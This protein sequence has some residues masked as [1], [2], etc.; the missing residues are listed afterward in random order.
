MVNEVK[1]KEVI[2][3]SEG[4]T[5]FGAG[6]EGRVGSY[7]YPTGKFGKW[8][9]K[10][11]ATKAHPHISQ[12]TSP[13][14]TVLAPLAGDAAVT[15]VTIRPTDAVGFGV[16]RTSI[17]DLVTPQVESSRRKRY[18][19]YEKMDDYP[20]VGAAF[21]IYADDCTQ[22]D[23]RGERWKIISD[24]QVV[25]DELRELFKTIKLDKT[26]WDIVRNTVKYGD[27]FTE[28]VVDL[29][30][31]K[32]GIQRIKVLN[33]KYILRVE[34]EYGYLTDF[35]QELPDKDTWD[36]FGGQ[37][38]D[39]GKRKYVV[40][41]KNQIIH[42]KL[43]TSDPL[44]YPYGKSM[45]ALAV[46]AYRSL[47]MMEDAMLIYRLTRAPERRIFYVD[48]GQLPASKAEMFMERLKQK[49]KKEKFYNHTTGNIDARY[50]PLSADEDFFVPVRGNQGTKI[51]TLPGA[52]NLGEVADVAYFRDKL[53]AALKVPKDFIVEKDKSPERKANLSQLDVKFARTVMRVQHAVENGL[54]SL[55]KKHLK[56]KGYPEALISNIRVELPDGSD[57]FTKRKL[58]IDEQKARVIQAVV[59][60]QLFAKARILKEYYDL[61]EQEIEEVLE[62]KKKE[63]EEE[64][65]AQAEMGGEEGGGS[66]PGYGEAG[67]QEG[68][69]NAAPTA[70]P[71][72]NEV[73]NKIRKRLVSEGGNS[74][75][76]NK[77]LGRV[78]N[79]KNNKEET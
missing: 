18:A 68:A 15:D 2:N 13:G 52:Q 49:F 26:Y 5:T 70:V 71:E 79:R 54:E 64:A 51:D 69:E 67:G 43:H 14:N 36:S 6:P 48:V 25:V 58:D 72:S 50:N 66:G 56:L 44:F 65:A 8:F 53:L 10:F 19:E 45:G 75:K 1:E 59:G 29:N 30:Q 62:E 61:T 63:L 7:F 22:R 12:Q 42:F 60:T 74:Y 41:D 4:Y 16:N 23:I 77:I 17:S 31:P 28:A 39:M 46:R 24:Y 20:E 21:D 9:A 11:F 3:E 33:P 73:F 40:L 35:I 47:K 37:G 57:M 78:L 32:K 38:E 76:R 55:A 34:N 27:C